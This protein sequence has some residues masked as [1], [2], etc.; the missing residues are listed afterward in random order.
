MNKKMINAALKDLK[1]DPYEYPYSAM[2][3]DSEYLLKRAKEE[4]EVG[5]ALKA[6]KI[7][8]LLQ[9]LQYGPSKK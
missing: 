3:L 4:L 2:S 5:N 9:A 1:V 7:L 6:G 8:V